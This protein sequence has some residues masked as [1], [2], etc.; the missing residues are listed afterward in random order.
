[1]SD[2]QKLP[3]MEGQNRPETGA[4]QFGD[5]WPG[6]FI[7][8]DNALFYAHVLGNVIKEMEDR[9]VKLGDHDWMSMAYL[10]GLKNL[11]QSCEAKQHFEQVSDDQA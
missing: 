7:R 9:G 3:A 4:M 5:D 6:I 10:T 8:G 11:L 2:I 1:M